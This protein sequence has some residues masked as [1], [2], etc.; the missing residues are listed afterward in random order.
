MLKFK[1][2]ERNVFVKIGSEM[3]RFSEV[4]FFVRFFVEMKDVYWRWCVYVRE[5]VREDVEVFLKKFF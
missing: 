4:F 5:D 3:K 1:Y 2:E